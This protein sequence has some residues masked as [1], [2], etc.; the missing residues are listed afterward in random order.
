MPEKL[1][2]VIIFLVIIQNL[3]A[4]SI[5]LEDVFTPKDI[6]RLKSGE[7]I[8][9]MYIKNDAVDENTDL[10]IVVPR[11]SFLKE[12]FSQYEMVTDEKAFIPY[13]LD[14]D[15]KLA[16]YNNL[17]AFSKLKGMK[18]YSRRVQEVKDLI[19]DSYRIKSP[20]DKSRTNDVSSL[21][22]PA[23]TTSY[24]VQKDNI[25]GTLT[26]KSDLYNENDNFILINTCEDKISKFIFNICSREEYKILTY[27]IY[28]GKSAVYF[29]Y[30]ANL[31]RIHDAAFLKPGSKL[32]L[33][34][35]T[36]S[37]RLRGATV[38]FAGMMGLNWDDKI[39]PWDEKKLKHGLYKN[40]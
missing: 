38:H 31:M 28:D 9:R 12:D 11:P 24:F 13:K 29:Y 4:Q 33:Y 14:N 39:N 17:I 15:S 25:F 40:Y 32:T 10:N 6:S 35:T 16:L 26:F 20:D 2:P 3:Y 5:K 8:T 1:I 27:L 7:I 23:V 21:T 36:F 18:Y 34:P 22:I 19:V 37:N 30:S